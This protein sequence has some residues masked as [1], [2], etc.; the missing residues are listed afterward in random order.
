MGMAIN[1]ENYEKQ[2][3]CL[4]EKKGKEREK[5]NKKEIK[6]KSGKTN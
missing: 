5:S 4:N 1:V 6:E 3:K 2:G